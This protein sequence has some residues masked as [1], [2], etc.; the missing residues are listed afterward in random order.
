VPCPRGLDGKINPQV[1]QFYLG[2]TSY[3]SVTH[4]KP[5]YYETIV[6]EWR[7]LSEVTSHHGNHRVVFTLNGFRQV[8][9]R[10]ID[11]LVKRAKLIGGEVLVDS[12]V[13]SPFM[14]YVHD[15]VTVPKIGLTTT[16]VYPDPSPETTTVDGG[17]ATLDA[18]TGWANVRAATSGSHADDSSA[19]LQDS[20]HGVVG[21]VGYGGTDWNIVRAFILFDTSAITDTDTVSATTLSLYGTAKGDTMDDD[22]NAYMS[23]TASNPSSNTALATADID[24][25]SDTEFA[26]G[27]DI[28]SFSTAGYND[29][30]FNASGI[31][32]VS[33][34]GVSK[35]AWREGHDIVNDQPASSSGFNFARAYSADQTGTS[36]DPKLVV[37]H[38]GGATFIPRI[39]FIM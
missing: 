1:T 30:A 21:I 35:F 36:T 20:G 5:V 8:H 16:T 37:V 29:Y 9:P 17:V 39:S 6:G 38:T 24:N 25:V 28:D 3:I 34:T 13:I 2:G 7:P 33:L 10:Y 15:M 27:I 18:T 4:V 14:Q 31:A 12:F 19:Q 23:V 26:T 22:A 11:W 32:A